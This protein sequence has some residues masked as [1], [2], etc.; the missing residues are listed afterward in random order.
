MIIKIQTINHQLPGV[1]CTNQYV[2]TASEEKVWVEVAVVAYEAAMKNGQSGE[3]A[4]KC[5]FYQADLIVE[6]MI[7]RR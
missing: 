6:E 7:K 4:R 5:A 3:A 2:L 1:L